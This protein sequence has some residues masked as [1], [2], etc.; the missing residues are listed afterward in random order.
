MISIDKKACCGCH[1]CA[2]VCPKQCITMKAD[3]EGF[4]YPQVNAADCIR[5]GACETVC[6]SL[7][8]RPE[9]QSEAP[10][11]YAVVNRD[12]ETRRQSSSGGVFTL[13][14][15]QTIHH[16][17]VVF[18][19]AMA[20]DQYSVRHIAVETVE[21]L[22]AL[23]G[24]KYLQSEIGRTYLQARKALQ[25]GREVLFSGTP[26]QIK[27]LN[28]FSQK[29]CPNLLCVDVICHG[30]PSP[31]LW[32]A[33]AQYVEAKAETKLVHV[34]FRCKDSGWTNFGIKRIDP[35]H[36]A[37]YVS[38]DKD[39]YMRMFLRDYCL[40]PSCYACIAK[41]QKSSDLTIADFWGIDKVLPAM[42]DGK[43]V[44]LVIARTKKGLDLLDCIG[45]AIVSKQVPYEGA[46]KENPSEYK[47][48]GCPAERGCFFEDMA[49]MTFAELEAKY[50]APTRVS[51]KSK[52]K[53][54]VKKVIL[55]T[56]LSK[57]VGGGKPTDQTYGMLF[58]FEE[59]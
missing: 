36:K 17:G 32:K 54:M 43:G 25:A 58:T 31:K 44:S 5:C 49:E 13:L 38:K 22:A 46:V 27:G 7:Q 23:R 34:N 30:V 33:Y 55:K 16:G 50:A 12:E 20:D 11:A 4:L 40:R 21:G 2:Q 47:S 19:A 26:C 39:P 52:A 24:S 45:E 37:M 3:S 14:A 9:P 57:F 15:A 48:A 6:P 35:N 51:L 8:A 29:D 1:A 28:T 41:P 10:Q 53:K 42:D 18:G 56:P 59:K